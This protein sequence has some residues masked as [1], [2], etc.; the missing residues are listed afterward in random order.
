MELFSPVTELKGVGKARAAQLQRLHLQTLYDLIAFFPRTYEDRTKLLPI[1]ALTP[2][3][4]ACFEAMV[5]SQPRLS[6]IR[7]GME[8]VK[9]R[10]SDNT[11]SLELVFFNQSYVKDQLL[12]GETYRFYG[13]LREGARQVQ[14]P[15]FERADAAGL[16]TGCILPVYAR[17]AGLSNRMLHSCVQQALDACLATLP[18]ILPPEVQSRCGLC[19]AQEAYRTIHAPASFEALA[20]ARRR[21]VFEEF[22][23]FSAGLFSL[24]ARRASCAAQAL[25]TSAISRFYALLP[26]EL[27]RAQRE[28]IGEILRDLSAPR[29]MNRL[30]QG[31]VGSGKTLVAAAA[32]FCAVQSGHQAAF[33]APTEILAEQHAQSLARLFA[34]LG[35]GVTLLTGSLPAARRREARQALADGSAQLVVGTHALLTQDVA[36]HD[37][38]LVVCDEQ[39]R[40]GVAQRAALRA[41]GQS[42]HL[43][44]MSAT[45]IPRTLA[46]LAYGE[47]DV[48]VLHELPP[49]RLPVE[50]FLVGEDKRQR[51]NGF[52]DRQCAQGHQVYI[53][54]PAVEESELESLK[55]A[56]ALA[57]TLQSAVF[58]HRRVGLLHGKMKPHEKEAALAA[59]A[60]GQTDILVATTV[61]E[62]GVDVP[63]ATLMVIENAERFGLSQLHQL[64]GR[65]GRG[66]AQS[67]CVLVSANRNEQTRRRLK[68]LCATT[69]GFKIAEE[70][71]ALRGPGDFLGSRQH[72]LPLFKVADLQMD[73]ET[74]TQAQQAAQ[75]ALPDA[76]ALE[77]PELSAL[78][79]R[80]EQLFSQNEQTLN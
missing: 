12:Y 35:I 61:V 50:T 10:V 41:K 57:E 5:I 45:P 17:T 37:L 70:D 26:F 67:Y 23:I 56:Q 16:V 9:L 25:S 43:L 69:D 38:A 27:T 3:E 1:C 19:S 78:R 24:R 15:A 62:V 44:V 47:L 65:V 7:K 58:P 18:D 4:S 64:R 63:N 6:R 75:Q 66:S 31:D 11:A 20:R 40:F 60:R 80:V 54:C 39:H 77:R 59:F 51:L 21:L 46:L 74:L 53:V 32:C 71:L 2:G 68:A 49:G 42:P 73:L 14:N 8:L 30:L 36:F 33:M 29:P 13:A 72:G 22:F 34:P 28:A 55:S 52:I 48:S 79:A 76:A